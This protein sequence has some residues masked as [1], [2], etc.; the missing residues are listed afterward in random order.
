MRRRILPCL[1]IAT[2]VVISDSDLWLVFE[3]NVNVRG[4][5]TRK[6]HTIVA[7]FNKALNP[8]SVRSFSGTRS[9]PLCSTFNFPANLCILAYQLLP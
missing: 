8:S 6:K 4:S 9:I 5:E 7:T 2:V 3:G 1:L